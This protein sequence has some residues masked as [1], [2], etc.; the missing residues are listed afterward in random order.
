MVV[1]PFMVVRRETD[2]E[3]RCCSLR[4]YD[5]RELGKPSTAAVAGATGLV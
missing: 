3:G 4:R 2:G 1:V 5:E